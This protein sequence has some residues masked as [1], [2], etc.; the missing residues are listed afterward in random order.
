[1]ARESVLRRRRLRSLA[2]ACMVTFAVLATLATSQVQPSLE[3][4]AKGPAF[5]LS[6]EHPSFSA[7]FSFTATPEALEKW[8]RLTLKLEH[9]EYWTPNA[10]AHRLKPE[11]TKLDG[12]SAWDRA[13]C[14]DGEACLG[15]Y[16]VVFRWPADVPSGT[17]RVE[18]R[19][20]GEILYSDEPV[21]GARVA[22]SIDSVTDTAEPSVRF[23]EESFVFGGKYR[24]VVKSVVIRLDK[25]VGGPISIERQAW[26]SQ[27]GQDVP[28]VLVR[29]P[30]SRPLELPPATA[31]RLPI[32]ADC[33]ASA[34]TVSF[35]IVM[36]A[37]VAARRAV[38]WGLIGPATARP[39]AT[40]PI[41]RCTSW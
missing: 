1:M 28:D 22:T 11:V 31:V 20:T 33:A 40:V 27:R 38:P 37:N 18:W 41:V 10:P 19:V 35:R 4:T 5:V 17:V 25:P 21:E 16:E 3:N 36:T 24:R 9:E 12:R 23:F 6:S 32:P 29:F 7:R 2:T 34:C 13:G 39:H 15:S 30:G 14:S 26:H 8:D